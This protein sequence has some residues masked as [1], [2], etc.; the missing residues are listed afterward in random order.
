MLDHYKD[1]A[2]AHESG[3]LAFGTVDSW[4]VYVGPGWISARCALR[5]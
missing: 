5:R 4:L 2:A 3:D 1:V